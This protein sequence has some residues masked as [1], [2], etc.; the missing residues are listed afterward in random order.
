[1]ISSR[2]RAQ[3]AKASRPPNLVVFLPD[4]HRPDTI[5]CYGAQQSFTPNL[6]KFSSQ[7]AVFQRVYVAQPICSPSR[8][9]LMT[10]TW[11]HSNGVLYNGVH[12][13]R[14]LKCLPE[15]MGAGDY[16]FG[17]LG[18]WHLGD[19]VKAQH[20]FQEWAS[21]HFALEPN[22][23]TGQRE[24][25]ISD[26]EKFLIE[27]QQQPDRRNG[28][29]FSPR[30]ASKL[31]IELSKPRFLETRAC[32]YL[33]RH[34]H[35]PFVLFVAFFEPH[36]PYNGPLNNA[37]PADQ[38]HLDASADH[39][40][41]SNMPARY[42]ALQ[43]K[44]QKVYGRAHEKRLRIKANYL[45]LVTEVDQSI[46]A[47]LSKIEQLGL[48]DNTIVMHAADHGDMMTAHGLFGKSVMFEEATRVPWL[49][50][51]PGQQRSFTIPQTVSYIDF[52]PT[53]LDLLGKPAD[54][55]CAGKSL[56]PLLHGESM[57]PGNVFVEWH[58]S[59]HREDTPAH[60]PWFRKYWVKRAMM[61]N[62][63]T[64][65]SPDGWKL[66]LRDAD[67]AELY[68]LRSDP[69]EL[70]NLYPSL[71]G[72]EIVQ[73]LTGEIHRWQESVGDRLKI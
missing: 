48:T 5:S 67:L 43:D 53:V 12:L 8:S 46:G 26:Y 51:L 4:G 31:P 10:G 66:S 55:Q 38:L 17:Y 44:W 9:A 22:P 15:M 72:K 1:M 59:R 30:F 27:N 61:E 7:S 29:G 24:V 45:G 33:T 28:R 47:V 64:V 34:Q 13:P 58:P 52:L 25:T 69:S 36:P 32:D 68:D 49:V 40:F 73:R 23:D 3:S 60:T 57:A 50:R 42:R 14:N 18:K 21:V 20:G 39:D 11:P 6:D 2:L 54:P 65:I 71:A 70:Q 16:H 19:E 56:A 62:T 41:G 35:E 63:R 37:H